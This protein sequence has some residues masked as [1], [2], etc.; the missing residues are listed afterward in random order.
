LVRRRSLELVSDAGKSP[1]VKPEVALDAAAV[2]RSVK[3]I[4]HEIAERNGGTGNLVLV[5]IVRRGANLAE[6]LAAALD[7]NGD[8]RVPVGTLDIS[9]YRDDGKGAPG[10]PRLLARDIRFPLDGKRVVLVDD[11][12]YTGRTVRA[13]LDALSDLG[14]AESIQLAVLVDRGEREIPIR[15]DYVG[16]N[17]HA[18]KGQRVYVRLA[19]VDGADAVVIGD[20]KQ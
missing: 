12:L 20:G 9:S 14:R 5:G 15:A 8:G 2:S 17:V 13:A 18:P 11:V 3:R 6:R 1:A 4:A 16:K 19:E 7:R 10:D